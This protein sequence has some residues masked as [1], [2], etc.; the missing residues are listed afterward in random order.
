MTAMD[1]S[2]DVKLCQ[3][4]SHRVRRRYQLSTVEPVRIVDCAFPA[5]NVERASLETT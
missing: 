3:P 4:D 5:S 1:S 2:A